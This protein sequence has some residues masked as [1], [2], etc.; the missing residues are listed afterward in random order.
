MKTIE[1]EIAV[2]GAGPAGLS[3]AIQAARSG[4]RVLLIDEN[5][6]SGGQ[7]FKQIHK[8]FGSAEHHAGTRGFRI[9]AELLEELRTYPRAEVLL[10]TVAYGF[11]PDR[12]LGIAHDGCACAVKAEKYVLAAGAMENALSFPGWTLPGVMGAGAAQTM[13]HINRV[14]PGKRVL[15]VGS[16]NVGLIVSYHLL[17]AGVEVCELIEAAPKIGGY[18]VHAG[19][20]RR[21]VVPISVSTT[22]KRALGK[23]AVTGAELVS[24]DG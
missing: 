1:T 6:A 5:R 2:V 7:L 22:V 21:A 14:R 16:G 8:F 15:M 23:D 4:A 11:F 3:A 13:L 9:G 12:T 24:L 20:L 18:G 19:K 17:Q 10:D